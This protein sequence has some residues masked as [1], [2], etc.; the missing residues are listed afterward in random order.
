MQGLGRSPN[1]GAQWRLQ[2]EAQGPLRG[3]HTASQNFLKEATP[4]HS[5]TSSLGAPVTR[6]GADQDFRK[7]GWSCLGWSVFAEEVR[8][9]RPLPSDCQLLGGRHPK[10][11]ISAS[12]GT[13]AGAWCL[14]H[15]KCS[16]NTGGREQ[17]REKEGKLSPWEGAGPRTTS[18]PHRRQRESRRAWGTGKKRSGREGVLSTT[19]D[20]VSRSRG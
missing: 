1:E 3:I 7:A 12:P 6:D 16:T 17:G 14:R 4:K 10:S 19:E 5:P 11:L 2:L 20:S 9:S 15:S 8:Q 13:K 18:Q